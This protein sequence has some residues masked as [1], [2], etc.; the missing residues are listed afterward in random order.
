M[1][2]SRHRHSEERLQGILALM[3]VSPEGFLTIRDVAE[4]FGIVN[5]Q[6]QLLLGIIG[7][8]SVRPHTSGARLEYV[9]HVDAEARLRAYVDT[10]SPLGTNAPLPSGKHV[11]PGFDVWP[12]DNPHDYDT[13]EFGRIRLRAD[14]R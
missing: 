5:Q 3:R 10:G 6:A 1:G 12:S 14:A 4:T 11:A 7:D 2:Q 13:D 8:R 9:E